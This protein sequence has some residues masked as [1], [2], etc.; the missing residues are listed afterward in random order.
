LIVSAESLP[1]PAKIDCSALRGLGCFC[2]ELRFRLR[3]LSPCGAEQAAAQR[4]F[5][6]ILPTG[7]KYPHKGRFIAGSYEFDPAT[8]TVELIVEFPTRTYC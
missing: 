4:E 7:D 6:L 2:S 8:Q 3:N 5:G 1:V